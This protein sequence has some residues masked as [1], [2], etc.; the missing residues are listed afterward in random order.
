[1]SRSRA[2]ISSSHEQPVIPLHD[3]R[4][5]PATRVVPFA[6]QLNE[7]DVTGRMLSEFR[8]SHQ[9]RLHAEERKGHGVRFLSDP[10]GLHRDAR[11]FPESGIQPDLAKVE[12]IGLEPTTSCMPCRRSPN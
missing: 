8:G 2:T 9:C 10:G 3:G 6:V 11:G 5:A 1:M 4:I 12:P 7:A